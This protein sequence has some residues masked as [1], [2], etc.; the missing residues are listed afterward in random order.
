[1]KNLNV[2]QYLHFLPVDKDIYVGW[3]RYFPSIFILND[4]ALELMDRIKHNQPIEPDEDIEEYLDAFKKYKFLYEGD[5]SAGDRDRDRDPSRENFIN[6]VREEVKRPNQFAETFFKE[7]RDYDDFKVVT[8][9][10]NLACAYCVNDYGRTPTGIKKRDEEKLRIVRMCVDQFMER[11]IR[12]GVKETKMFFNGGEILVEWELLREIV[13]GTSKKYPDIRVEYGLNTNLTLLTEEMAEFLVRHKFKVHVS[14]DGY[15]EAHDRT[16]KY[17]GGKGSFDDVLEKVE[18]YRKYNKDGMRSF[19]GTIEFPDQ[20]DPEE[21]YK[22]EKYGF[23]S[24]RLAPNLLNCPEEDAVKKA[25]L[26][27]KFL[28]LNERHQFQV[29]ELVFNQLKRKVNQEEYRFTFNCRGLS[30]LYGTALELNLSTFSLSYLCGFVHDTAVPIDELGKNIYNPK[31]W[32][33]SYKF[34]TGRMESLF[35]NC[36]DCELAGICLGGCILSG[37]DNQNR[38][39]KAACAYQK[40]MWKIYAQKAYDDSKKEM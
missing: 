21:V 28:E 23:A 19:Q 35:E 10:C 3:N 30:A 26:M 14:I 8:D 9:D 40:E 15:K 39:N 18:L 32:D 24:A 7:E 1:M 6:M 2:S 38:V 4:A 22:M 34:I 27:G 20:F 11:K 5:P 33:I 13:E 16:R 17:H 36:M 31:L 12:G 37:L 25:Q 29:T